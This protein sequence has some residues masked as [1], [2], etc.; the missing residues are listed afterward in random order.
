MSGF[1]RFDVISLI[2][3][4]NEI[5]MSCFD[6]FQIRRSLFLSSLVIIITGLTCVVGV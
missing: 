2:R 3:V 4:P 6:A 1:I 5:V